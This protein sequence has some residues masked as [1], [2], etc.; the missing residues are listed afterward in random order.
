MVILLY[1]YDLLRKFLDGTEIYV[2]RHLKNGTHFIR[3]DAKFKE[4]G[5]KASKLKKEIKF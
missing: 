2:V 5:I 1:S 4:N 3:M